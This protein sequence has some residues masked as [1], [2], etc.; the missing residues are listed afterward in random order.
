MAKHNL[1][2][3]QAATSACDA[4]AL[5]S[6]VGWTALVR[7][8]RLQAIFYRRQSRL[9]QGCSMGSSQYGVG[10]PLADLATERRGPFASSLSRLDA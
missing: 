3:G 5:L 4:D 2:A 9:L 7:Q 1:P 8:P 6:W 10:E